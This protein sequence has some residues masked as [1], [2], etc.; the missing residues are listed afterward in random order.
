MKHLEQSF[1]SISKESSILNF[2]VRN[3]VTSPHPWCFNFWMGCWWNPQSIISLLKHP[4]FSC[5][6]FIG[7]FH[8]L[9]VWEHKIIHHCL[10]CLKFVFLLIL[11]S[12][13]EDNSWASTSVHETIHLLKGVRLQNNSTTALL[14]GSIGGAGYYHLCTGWPGTSQGK[15]PTTT[16][17]CS[18]VSK[19]SVKGEW[20]AWWASH[21]HVT[22]LLAKTWSDVI[23]LGMMH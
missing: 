18:H 9:S 16:F 21:W 8:A 22:S 3:T 10:S 12:M 6:P 20:G 2:T 7:Y 15:S 4:S 19:A 11:T 5:L 17:P 13:L 14:P 1:T 23:T